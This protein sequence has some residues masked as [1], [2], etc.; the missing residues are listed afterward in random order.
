VAGGVGYHRG[1][2]NHSRSITQSI[3]FLCPALIVMVGALIRSDECIAAPAT[4]HVSQWAEPTDIPTPK[5]DDDDVT[6]NADFHRRHE[7]FLARAKQGNIDL[8]FLGDS[9][10]AD[11]TWGNHPRLFDQFFGKYRTANFGVGGDRTEHVL[12]RIDN[13]ELD[14][15]SPKVVVLLI[16]TNNI[17]WPAAD[18]TRGITA[19]VSTI[20][21]KL[22][23]T[24]VLLLGI[25][26]RGADPNDPKVIAMR[27]K[28][29]E[30]NAA[31]ARLDD[32]NKTRFLDIGQQFLQPDGHIDR[33]VMP[34]ALHPETRGLE[35]WANAMMPLLD[36]MMK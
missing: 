29:H 23:T 24:K 36:Q 7:Q 16:G 4:T 34:D 33:A 18:I 28:I 32:S 12:W 8:L 11:W 3:A 30:V 26:P 5:V 2:M 20:H 22:P 1:E 9:I 10:T 35:I 27:Q 15:I 21:Q 14:G 17:G 31:L 13:G 19:I 6:P 25:F